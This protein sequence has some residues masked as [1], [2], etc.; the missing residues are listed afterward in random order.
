MYLHR[1]SWHF[2]ATLTEAFPCFFLSCRANSRVK[3]AKDETRPALFQI[4]VLFVVW[5]FLSFCV[6][7]LCKCVLYYCHR[8]ATQLQLTNISDIRHSN[9]SHARNHVMSFAEVNLRKRETAFGIGSMFDCSECTLK[10]QPWYVTFCNRCL[11]NEH[12][13]LMPLVVNLKP[14]RWAKCILHSISRQ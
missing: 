2:S 8:V 7:F 10:I 6:L 9:T 13:V 4:C 12:I 14:D 3:P 11:E 1:A 5:F